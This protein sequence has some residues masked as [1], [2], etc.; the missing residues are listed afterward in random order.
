MTIDDKRSYVQ[1]LPIDE[2]AAQ[3]GLYGARC[4]NLM[5]KFLAA[6]QRDLDKKRHLVPV[7]EGAAQWIC[8]NAQQL[9]IHPKLVREIMDRAGELTSMSLG[10]TYGPA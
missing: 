10:N 5:I 1:E 9:Q 2:K 3:V 4:P 8:M 6:M 7:F